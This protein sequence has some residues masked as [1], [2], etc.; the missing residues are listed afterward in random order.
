MQK[1][2]IDVD[3]Q[4]QAFC[5]ALE[6]LLNCTNIL[7]IDMAN[8]KL[9]TIAPIIKNY[10]IDYERG[11][12]QDKL[13]N[14]TLTLERTQRWIC[15]NLRHE[16]ALKTVDLEQ[17]LEGKAYAFVHVHSAAMLS[18]ITDQTLITTEMC[19]E[20]LLFDVDR[21][22]MIQQEFQYIITSITIM[23]KVKHII[24]D[25][26]VLT[27]ITELFTPETKLEINLEQTILE[28]DKAI[29]HTTLTPNN[30]ET[31]LKN[32]KESTSSTDAVRKIIFQRIKN[33]WEKI[34][35][36][37]SSLHDINIINS[38]RAF[39]PRIE[40]AVTKLISL[41]NLNRTVH[42]L[43]YNKLIEEES[44]KLKAEC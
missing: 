26:Q 44:L 15:L 40:K 34:M 28:I 30:R 33:I 13:I 27:N 29:Q 36:D 21:L 37:S 18:L 16:V 7:R 14:G 1:A 3:E 8:K 35:K 5:K 19:P 4:P 39:I 25:L 31:L 17:L 6:F 22:S 24:T 23:V 12:F 41:T 43:I 42:L 20:T 2:L 38:V 11:K 10:G 32:L 9:K